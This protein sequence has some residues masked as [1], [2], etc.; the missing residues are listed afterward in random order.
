MK[1][2]WVALSRSAQQ[3]LGNWIVTQ[4]AITLCD[5][6]DSYRSTQSFG[7]DEDRAVIQIEVTAGLKE[8]LI[9]LSQRDGVRLTNWIVN[10]VELACAQ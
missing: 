3:T 8:R 4:V 9:A 2:R 7:P 5:E 6:L 10:R 1:G